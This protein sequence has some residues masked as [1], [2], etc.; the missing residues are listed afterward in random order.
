LAAYEGVLRRLTPQ[1]EAGKLSIERER[2]TLPEFR[3]RIEAALVPLAELE[4]KALAAPDDLAPYRKLLIK[5]GD[6]IVGL[7]YSRPEEAQ[8]LLD[9]GQAVGAKLAEAT[10]N[11]EVKKAATSPHAWAMQRPMI[12]EGRHFAE[13]VGQPADPLAVKSWASGEPTTLAGLRG[14]VVLICSFPVTEDSW[15]EVFALLQAWQARYESRGLTIIGV[16]SNRGKRW[17]D[18][19]QSLDQGRRP[20]EPRAEFTLQQEHETL[21]KF[22]AFHGLKI[23]L[24]THDPR[25]REGNL[26]LKGNAGLVL[27]DQQGKI[28]AIRKLPHFQ[29][30]AEDIDRGL[31]ELMPA[32]K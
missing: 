14:R 24:A 9:A 15:T 12:S 6:A 25:G 7:A 26:D 4:A 10:R 17:N 5:L 21:R 31:A 27:I 18:A 23:P 1:T 2:A 28:R 30:N 16:A 22:V 13:L 32:A 20:G 11:E 8:K 29:R 3:E 19:T